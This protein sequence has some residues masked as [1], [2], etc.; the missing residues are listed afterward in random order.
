M[1]KFEIHLHSAGT[2][3]CGKSTATEMIDAAKQ[4]GYAGI[5]MTNHF[6]QGNTC[7]DRKLPWEEFVNAYEQ[8]YLEA[9][10]YGEAEGIT[11]FFGIEEVYT[12]GKEV[13]IYGITPA[14]LKS[15]TEYKSFSPT[16]KLEFFRSIGATLIHAHP[17]RDRAYIPNPD[18]KP[19]MKYFDGIECY[20]YFNQPEENVKAFVFAKNH[21]TIMT[22]GCDIHNSADFGKAG[23]AF[24]EEIKT[25]E[26]F[27]KNLKSGSFELITPEYSE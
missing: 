24:Y 22:S 25:Y 1:F 5:V 15:C 19:D 16:Q 12:A 3:A 9:K 17:F 18:K 2:S 8:E 26:Q 20:N 23:L 4:H 10:A 7:V 14:Q 6:Y 11:V 13:L 27:I 21:N